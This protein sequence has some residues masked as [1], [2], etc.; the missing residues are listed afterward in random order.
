MKIFF[1]ENFQIRLTLL[2]LEILNF[3]DLDTDAKF[4]QPCIQTR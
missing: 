3:M 4:S 2:D 1:F